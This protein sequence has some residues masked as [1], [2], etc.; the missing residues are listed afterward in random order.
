M[1]PQTKLRL[2]QLAIQFRN[3]PCS[4]SH[5]HA[6]VWNLIADLGGPAA[7]TYGCYLST[8]LRSRWKK[9][10]LGLD[11]AAAIERQTRALPLVT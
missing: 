10:D 5:A 9:R 11:V 7:I 3:A 2:E 1:N 6:D 4:P 8:P